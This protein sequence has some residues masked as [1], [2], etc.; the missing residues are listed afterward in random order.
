LIQA[1]LRLKDGFLQV[2]KIHFSDNPE[3]ER[4]GV[5]GQAQAGVL[6]AQNLEGGVFKGVVATDIGGED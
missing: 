5:T 2:V 6:L 3:P 4:I 1:G